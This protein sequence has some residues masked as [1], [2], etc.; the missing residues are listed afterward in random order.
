MPVA[1]AG[2]DLLDRSLFSVVGAIQQ[3]AVIND[4]GDAGW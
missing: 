2:V 4:I 1:D 3:D